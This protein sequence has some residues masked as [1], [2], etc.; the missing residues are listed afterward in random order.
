MPVDKWQW[1][2]LIPCLPDSNLLSLQLYISSGNSETLNKKKKT[3]LRIR[4]PHYCIK[5]LSNFTGRKQNFP[6]SVCPRGPQHTY[7]WQLL[8]DSLPW[9][10]GGGRVNSM[11]LTSPSKKM[12]V[13]ISLATLGLSCSMQVLL[14]AARGLLA[15]AC[16]TQLPEPSPQGLSHWTIRGTLTSSQTLLFLSFS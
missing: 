7:Q 8:L 12:S 15:A 5:A 2:D 3:K 11:F 4:S 13:S 6:L 9:R 10:Q 1:L 14:A 16:G